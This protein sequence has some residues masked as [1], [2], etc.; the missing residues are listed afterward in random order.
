VTGEDPATVK[1]TWALDEEPSNANDTDW[2]Q[3]PT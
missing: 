1:G 2:N 3:Q